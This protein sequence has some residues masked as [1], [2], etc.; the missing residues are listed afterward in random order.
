MVGRQENM[1]LFSAAIKENWY[2]QSEMLAVMDGYSRDSH[3]KT[4]EAS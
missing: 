3:Q 1:R 4:D 2:L